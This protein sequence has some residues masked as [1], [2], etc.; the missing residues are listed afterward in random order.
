MQI[1]KTLRRA[2]RRVDNAKKAAA[3]LLQT[4]PK[5]KY[6]FA[7]YYK[8]AKVHADRMLFESFNGKSISDSAFA[9]LQEMMEQGIAG[10][11]EIFYA[12]NDVDRD[13]SFVEQN[14][15]PVKLVDINSRMYPYVLATAKYLLGNVCFPAYFIRKPEQ[16]YVQTWHGTPLKTLGKQMRR[17]MQSMFLAQ[18]N[19]LQ[20]SWITFPND[21][22]RD[23][24]MR[25]YNL[26]TLYRGKV[27]MVGYPRNAIFLK[28]RDRSMRAS[29]DLEGT[30]N[31][32][33]MPTWRGVSTGQV[34]IDGYLD[35]VNAILER[36][37]AALG[38]GQRLYVNFHTMVADK[39]EL[40]EYRH[41]A[42]FPSEVNTYDF[43]AQMDVLITDYSSVLFDFALTGR[44]VVLFCYDKD[45]YLADRG[46]YL[47][48]DELPFPIVETTD[49][50]CKM[51]ARES[52]RIPEE[53]YAAFH[54]RFLN[55]D[56]ANNAKDVLG[57]LLG[58]VPERVQVTDYSF[59][60]QREWTVVDAA[61]QK[62]IR[63]VDGLFQ[64]TDAQS[65]L[66][67]LN[68][69]GFG[70]GKS[71]HVCERYRDYNFIFRTRATPVT[72]AERLERK[73]GDRIDERLA[74][75]EQDRLLG[76]GFKC[77]GV[78]NTYVTSIPGTTFTRK[79]QQ[80]VPAVAEMR[81]DHLTVALLDDAYEC[82]DV[83]FAK[84]DMVLWGR[85]L[86]SRE[87]QLQAVDVDLFELICNADFRA[88][89]ALHARLCLIATNRTTNEKIVALPVT[90]A[91]ITLDNMVTLGLAPAV[92]SVEDCRRHLE[93]QGL[94][95]AD[96]PLVQRA[97]GTH[98]ALTPRSANNNG[99]LILYASNEDEL[100]S[101]YLSPQ[102]TSVAT[103]D[104][105]A[106]VISFVLPKGDYRVAAV[107]LRNRLMKSDTS[108]ELS[109]TVSE[110]AVA[111]RVR[112]R[113][114][115]EGKVFDGTFWDLYV[116]L[117]L[118]DGATRAVVVKMSKSLKR[119]L[120]FSTRQ[121]VT[122]DGSVLFPHLGP[123]GV[124]S[125][126]Q[127]ELTPYDVPLTRVKEWAAFAT[128]A[129]LRPY[130]KSK[131]IWLVYEKFCNGAQDNGFRFFEYCMNNLP[132][133]ERMHIFYVLQKSSHDR[134]KVESYARN[135]IDFM[136][137]KHMLYALSARILVA[138][139]AR[140]HLYL[141]RPRR[142][143]IT[144]FIRERPIFFL[145]HGVT[146]LKRVDYLFGKRGSTPM[147]YFLTTSK[148][149]QDI[150]V[151]HFG[152]DVHHAPVLGF[153]RWDA[154]RDTSA[155]EEHPSILLMPT[156][157]QWLEGVDDQTFVE[158]EYCQTYT[159]LLNDDRL[160]D[161]L[162]QT[163]TTLKFFI[164]PK[165]SEQ[166]IHFGKVSPH[167]ELVPMG[168]EPLNELLMSC[169]ALI[170]DYSSV[171]W[172]MLYM[173]K[174]VLFFQFDQ[175]RYVDEV[176]AYVDLNEELPGP[177]SKTTEVLLH[178]V[179]TCIESGFMLGQDDRQ[180]AER[181]FDFRDNQNAKRT[182]DF[183][184]GKKY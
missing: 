10:D 89:N 98:I 161:L 77:V 83:F 102:V 34:D 71:S 16:I 115:P 158:S 30:T 147:T 92:Y 84:G 168:S 39:V 99:A 171:A 14:H 73:H 62:R 42:P 116:L 91:S 12:T 114:E 87:R 58:S 118:E 130:W 128:Y 177:V 70:P 25:D 184:L 105:K 131:R 2:A 18:H 156:W 127:R 43:L 1:V 179:R 164:H 40:G 145:Q 180:K 151:K 167:V 148:A 59:N 23:A 174:P 50:L 20:A 5:L 169:K 157:R 106:F 22:T 54:D 112:A 137:F 36:V 27:A 132:E 33:Y 65:E 82:T 6:Y 79:L 72:I 80:C 110:R 120:Y 124:F 119:S 7:Y 90:T 13:R 78:R 134:A 135:V 47:S 63:D 182:Y 74:A 75:R 28:P 152:Y 107:M 162:E 178:D 66:I 64:S 45:E 111:K 76:A 4:P 121:C 60:A 142:N 113:F 172:D 166:I 81:D 176:G 35:D 17:G 51:L 104:Q 159:E 140:P 49:E 154:L 32:A 61:P 41:I 57:L 133:E 53:G 86:S 170:T 155:Q 11:Y 122:S 96:V 67:V 85:P 95:I 117:T 126:C 183:L 31:F 52:Y 24:M 56:T 93:E 129:L 9:V 175:D 48:L 143:I 139:D 69:A 160:T 181:W 68:R 37:D 108:Y 109:F 103:S 88:R 3:K 44:P 46:M 97:K 146:A 153:S 144:R 149:E 26:S 165:F 150:V 8:Y 141:W 19:F 101:A 123:R 38:D 29:Y 15:L 136:S 21:F 163:E 125:L 173:D 94:N 55:Y 138:S 100:A